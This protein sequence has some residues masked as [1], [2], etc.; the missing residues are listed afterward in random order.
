MK[1]KG[2]PNRNNL[3]SRGLVYFFTL[4]LFVLD[5]TGWWIGMRLVV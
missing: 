3:I 1:K 4:L 2:T 5:I